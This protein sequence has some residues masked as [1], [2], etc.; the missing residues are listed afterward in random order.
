MNGKAAKRIRAVA[1]A[2]SGGDKFRFNAL[3]S[4]GKA[5]YKRHGAQFLGTQTHREFFA[6]RHGRPA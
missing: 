4:Q 5:G 2:Q 6:Q 1:R 3:V